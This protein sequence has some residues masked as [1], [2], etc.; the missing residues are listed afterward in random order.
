MKRLAT[1][2]SA[3]PVALYGLYC[4]YTRDHIAT[5]LPPGAPPPDLRFL[6]LESTCKGDRIHKAMRDY[7]AG[8]AR[9]LQLPDGACAENWLRYE[10]ADMLLF[11]RSRLLDEKIEG[12][13]EADE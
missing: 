8:Q 10:Y 12:E 3:D 5:Y 9:I 13:E 2:D 4:Q 6:P 11:A 1:L 7:M